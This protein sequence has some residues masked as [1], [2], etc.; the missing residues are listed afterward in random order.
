MRQMT[1]HILEII[2]GALPM[3]GPCVDYQAPFNATQVSTITGG[4][5]PQGRCLSLNSSGEWVLGVGATNATLSV[6]F[7][8]RSNSDDYDVKNDGGTLS[9]DYGA[10]S[11]GTPTGKGQAICG[12]FAGELEST[13][14]QTA[15]NYNLGNA[16]SAPLQSSGTASDLANTAGVLTNASIKPYQ[17]VVVGYVSKKFTAAT[18]NLNAHGKKVLRFWSTFLPKLDGSGVSYN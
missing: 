14:F 6:P 5:I 11:P 7:F 3:L 12:L 2:K 15:L 18:P 1:D 10:W 4:F 8:G 9:T 13:E 17:N 16:L